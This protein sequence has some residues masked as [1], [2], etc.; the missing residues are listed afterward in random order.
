MSHFSRKLLVVC[1]YSAQMNYY[2][3]YSKYARGSIEKGEG[4]G[5]LYIYPSPRSRSSPRGEKNNSRLLHTYLMR[6]LNT[7]KQRDRSPHRHTGM[8]IAFAEKSLISDQLKRGSYRR[9]LQTESELLL[10]EALRKSIHDL[11][12]LYSQDVNIKQNLRS[13]KHVQI[14]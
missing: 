12:R 11:F 2:T 3:L 10:Q 5:H 4:E 14:T 6:V 8:C 9:S 13:V 1:R 7:H